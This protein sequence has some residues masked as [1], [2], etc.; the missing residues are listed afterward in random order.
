MP[1]GNLTGMPTAA[2]T[3]TAPATSASAP[4]TFSG[5]HS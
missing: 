5:P 3:P 4:P 2:K 1:T